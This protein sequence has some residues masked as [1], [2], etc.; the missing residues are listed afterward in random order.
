[1]NNIFAIIGS[2][3][4]QSANLKLVEHIALEMQH[5][6]QLAVFDDLST[7]P[8]FYPEQSLTDTPQVVLEFRKAIETAD[9][10]M[11]CTP[12]Y[13][14]SIPSC[15]KNAIEWCVATTVF[16]DK[17]VGLITAAAS[18]IKAHEE[19]QLIMKTIEASFTC[20]TTL[21]IQGI[22]GKIDDHGNLHHE[23]TKQRLMHFLSSFDALI[24]YGKAALPN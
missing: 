18:G 20:D 10:V 24:A 2:A 13:V 19:L 6:W 8:H 23:E 1:V 22:K 11:I 16:S 9:A 3:S 4:R 5:I 21:L 15:L 12:E 17:P 7:L 14:F